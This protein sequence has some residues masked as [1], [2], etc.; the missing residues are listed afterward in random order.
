MKLGGITWWRGNYG[1]ILQAYALSRY[2]NSVPGIDYEVIDQ[3]GSIASSKGILARIR[4][5][6]PV[7]IY[8]KVIHKYLNPNQR[9]R[10]KALDRFIEDYI[11]ISNQ[12]YSSGSISSANSVYD[13]F[14]CGSDQIWNF[15]IT[16]PDQMYWLSFAEK[17]KKRIAYAPSI[18]V[19]RLSDDQ[20]AFVSKMISQFDAVSCREESGSILLNS[21]IGDERCVTVLDPTMLL[22]ADEWSSL[23]DEARRSDYEMPSKYIFAYIL[24]GS[25]EQKRLVEKIS[26]QMGM[27][28]ICFP[29]LQPEHSDR[30]DKQFGDISIYDANPADFIRYIRDAELVF[31]D[32]FHCCVFSILFHRTFFVLRKR[33]ASQSERL[34]NLMRVFHTGDR[35]IEPEA[36]ID[37]LNEIAPSSWNIVEKNLSAQRHRSVSYLLN[38]LEKDGYDK[39]YKS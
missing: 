10:M 9:I 19:K 34:D 16:N 8:R 13:G 12:S 35:R 29:G 31:T 1:S 7:S 36:G 2:L 6:D 14:I 11:P 25:A 5:N 33:Q 21:I 26:Q 28:L 30:Y 22:P 3:Y 39:C 4:E 23:A 27:K 20:T 15:G 24:N 17:G 32:S 37:Y 38:A 18:G